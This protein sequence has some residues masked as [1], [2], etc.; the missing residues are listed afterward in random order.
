[1]LKISKKNV[2][3]IVF[4]IGI[5][6]TPFFHINRGVDFSDVGYNLANYEN[7]P[8][9]NSTWMLSTFLSMLTGKLLTY[10]PLGHTMLGMN[11]YCATI[12]ALLAAV[13]YMLISK[14][15]HPFIVGIAEIIALLLNWCPYVVLYHYLSYFT[16]GIGGL[17]LVE[18]IVENNKKKMYLAGALI[19]LNTFICFPNV[20]DVLIVMLIAFDMCYEKRWIICNIRRFGAAY[21]TVFV[22][23]LSVISAFFGVGAYWKMISGLFSM[24][25][26]ANSYKPGGMIS[27]IIEGYRWDLP[28]FF[29]LVVLVLVCSLLWHF[30]GK[31][32]Q[33]ICIVTIDVLGTLFVAR[34]M[35]YFG[36]IMFDYT[37]YMSVYGLS[38]VLILGCV[39]INLFI[40][41]D[42]KREISEKLYCLLSLT[43][44]VI[45]P[46]GSNS[47]VYTLLNAL[48]VSLP[49]S[50]GLLFPF[51][52]IEEGNVLI[53]IPFCVF[54]ILLLAQSF[55]FHASFIY[56]DGNSLGD[57]Y[58]RIENNEVLNG[59]MTS[60]EKVK[61]IEEASEFVY[62]RELI[63]K[64]AVFF[65]HIPIAS[66]IFG[67]PNAI[68][69]IWPSLDS[70]P[71]SEL[72]M[73][74][75]NLEELPLIVYAAGFGDLIKGEGIMNDK[76]TVVSDF[77]IYNNYVE[78][79]RND[80]FVICALEGEQ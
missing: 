59:M 17:F 25:E 70:Y 31:K 75:G 67:M 9:V 51:A 63:G 58:V 26:E 3:R 55:L 69:H 14:H 34:V 64:R 47:G 45:T 20:L 2:V 66:Y 41:F 38:V 10:L 35:R 56:R 24:T 21:I 44:I 37:D 50:I 79:F 71:I 72:K 36:R 5:M 78:I 48:F 62:R 18:A 1:L 12:I 53:K 30:F 76:S 6:I 16:F 68:S 42:K 8:S 49:V 29:T 13:T 77:L 46:I 33:R 57:T 43:I 32:W 52:E 39:L 61:A 65:G 7:F 73:E 23:M 28:Y 19:S 27:T 11:V 74:L 54:G 40:L 4:L 22:V 80:S 60:P 15:F